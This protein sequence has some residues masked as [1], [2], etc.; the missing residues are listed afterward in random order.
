MNPKPHADKVR[1]AV[2]LA[3]GAAQAAANPIVASW[4]R[5]LDQ[6][7]L[8]PHRV[9]TTS[10]L[11]HT[12][13]RDI[14]CTVDDLLASA[15]SEVER[16]F[17]RLVRH[18]YIVTVHDKN[19]VSVL[20]YSPDSHL[21]GK[22]RSSRLL[23][24]SVWN[25]ENQGTNGVGTCI[26]QGGP[27]VIVGDEHFSTSLT[28]MT[29]MVAPIFSGQEGLIGALNVTTW[30]EPSREASV[31][32]QGMV[33]ES[34]RLIENLYFDRRNAGTRLLRLS[35]QE[36]FADM[37]S[38]VRLVLDSNDRIVDGSPA[39]HRVLNV[40]PHAV[41]GCGI[42]DIIDLS[43]R[44]RLSDHGDAVIRGTSCGGEAVYLKWR[45]TGPAK[46]ARVVVPPMP[47]ARSRERQ[48]DELDP[49]TAEQVRIAQR[50][51]NRRLPVLIRGETGTGKSVLAKVLHESST[52][53]NAPLVSIN[54]AAIPKDLIE[55]ELF[56][57]RSGAFTGA[58][59]TGSKGRILEANGGT[60]FLDEIGDMPMELQTRLLQVLSD[61]EFVPVG[62]VSSV[63][64]ALSVISASLHDVAALVQQGRFRQD[65]YFR[66]NGSTISLSPLRERQDRDHLI[67]RV[68]AE[69]AQAVG[70]PEKRLDEAT[71]QFLVDYTWPGNLR[72]LRHC[73]RYAVTISDED[74]VTSAQLPP[75][76]IGGASAESSDVDQRVLLLTLQ[77]TAWNV[78]AAAKRMGVSRATL[79]RRIKA[80]KLERRPAAGPATGV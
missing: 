15:R 6:Y 13:L 10:I 28:H 77:Q 45:N 19:S 21:E 36:D 33:G 63:K 5:C 11:T 3:G 9:P 23:A 79:H 62:G 35:R 18:D 41:M 51:V 64:V 32:V 71:F 30:R 12:E 80:L 48:P 38:E 25:E 16:L 4:R 34:A 42:H 59:K 75:H 39:L 1:S 27:V 65:L 57:Y 52:H 17:S 46:S 47:P 54:C 49:L 61:G 37:S 60:L 66:L 14:C 72:E 40:P 68:F 73:C 7:G 50:L 70:A 76:L 58:S 67:R 74:V 31:I 56:G 29:C 69:E 44:H 55:S 53:A 26:K 2:M 20:V 43:G 8:E 78:S 24:G 22:A